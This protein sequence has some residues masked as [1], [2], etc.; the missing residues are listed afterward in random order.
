TRLW[1]CW[2]GWAAVVGGALIGFFRWYLVPYRELG[3]AM[4]NSPNRTALAELA[5]ENWLNWTGNQIP[6]SMTIAAGVGGAWLIRR[7]KF[8]A[9]WREVKNPVPRKKIEAKLRE[10]AQNDDRPPAQSLDDLRIRLGVGKLTGE[11]CEISGRAMKRHG[12]IPGASGYGKSR[13]FE[14]LVY[15]LVVSPHARPL[16]IGFLFADMKAVPMLIESMAGG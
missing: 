12:F 10:L 16:G 6:F 8:Q 11:A 3:T 1:V 15:E 2:G 13:T 9:E 7:A 14:Q 5:Q 4:W